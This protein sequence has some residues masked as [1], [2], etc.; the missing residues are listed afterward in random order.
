MMSRYYEW[1]Q[2]HPEI[3]LQSVAW[4]TQSRR[5]AHK[6]KKVIA[7]LNVDQVRSNIEHEL[8]SAEQ[9]PGKKFSIT[10]TKVKS[11]SVLGIFTGQGA[12]WVQMGFTLIANFPFAREK[13]DMMDA[14]L[15]DLPPDERPDWTIK[16]QLAAGAASSRLSEAAFSQPLCTAV[17]ILLVDILRSANVQ[18]TAV[19]GHSS[20]MCCSYYLLYC[21][22]DSL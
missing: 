11:Q 14:T 8:A 10:S 22:L 21:P 6:F 9:D 15:A 7:G 16:D 4:A 20:G 18:L 2:V 3:D 17:Q 13:V 19:V 12:Q 1:L 5:S